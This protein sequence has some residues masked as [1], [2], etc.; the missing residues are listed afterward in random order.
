[1]KLIAY[2]L[3]IFGVSILI[4][5][6][7]FIEDIFLCRVLAYINIT[8]AGLGLLSKSIRRDISISYNN[9]NFAQWA[10]G[11]AAVAGNLYFSRDYPE[12]FYVYAIINLITYAVIFSN[13]T[14]SKKAENVGSR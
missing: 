9:M 10:I 14:F 6:G 11:S 4:H 5:Y 2:N 13:M 1:M 8:L 3:F 12:Y 7:G